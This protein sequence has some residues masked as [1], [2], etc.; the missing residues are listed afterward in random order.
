MKNQTQTDLEKLLYKLILQ[1][2]IF[3]RGSHKQLDLFFLNLS[4]KLKQGI[5]FHKLTPE[6]KELSKTFRTPDLAEITL[7]PI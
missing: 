2:S 4:Q 5:N 3:T 1:F 7:T 6:L